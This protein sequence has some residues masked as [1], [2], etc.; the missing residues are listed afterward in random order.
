MHSL[1][2]RGPE[3]AQCI[4]FFFLCF[5]LLNFINVYLL[6]CQKN[7]WS[8]Y[9]ITCPGT[10]IPKWFSYT[11]EGDVSTFKLPPP[12]VSKNFIGIAWCAIFQVNPE[13]DT[14]TPN[15]YNQFWINGF[16][17]TNKEGTDNFFSLVSPLESEHM[18][19][20]F[21]NDYY[22]PTWLQGEGIWYEFNCEPSGAVVYK[23]FGLHYVYIE[24][25]EV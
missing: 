14:K 12:E 5:L 16:N 19:L 8:S 24:D 22:L 2:K 20:C 6:L 10:E 18:W 13:K 25:N 3:V 4:Q 1:C 7:P 21:Y 11:V 15:F 17:V 23:K 9:F